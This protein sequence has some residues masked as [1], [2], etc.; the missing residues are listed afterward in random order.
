MGKVSI[1]LRGWRFDEDEVFTEDGQLKPLEDV[2][3]EPRRRLVRLAAIHDARCDGCWLEHGEDGREEWRKAEVVYGEPLS[4]VVVC[5]EHEPDFYYWY[6]EAGGD[7]YR[8]S[9]EFDDRFH[10]WFAD[11]GRAPEGYEGI[12]HVETEPE[13]VP[14]PELP[15]LEAL[16]REL[17]EDEQ[18]EID[19]RDADLGAEYPTDG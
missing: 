5:R 4:E 14:E 7:R 2:P 18:V 13:A 19:L 17:P 16:N 3:K 9:A 10:E 8:G 6:L 15:D 11:G 12:E 1:G